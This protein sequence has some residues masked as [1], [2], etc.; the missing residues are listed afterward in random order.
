MNHFTVKYI[1]LHYLLSVGI[2]AEIFCI[3]KISCNAPLFC[4]GLKKFCLSLKNF[5]LNMK[6]GT[7][8]A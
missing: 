2:F 3:F 7:D 6:Y 4:A 1:F 8:T 5:I